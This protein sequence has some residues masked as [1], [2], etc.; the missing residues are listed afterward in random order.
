MGIVDRAEEV[1]RFADQPGDRRDRFGRGAADA[2]PDLDDR[3]VELAFGLRG[4]GVGAG[5]GRRLQ[6]VQRQPLAASQLVQGMMGLLC[7]LREQVG[8]GLHLGIDAGQQ[9]GQSPV[10][11]LQGHLAAVAKLLG[12]RRRQLLHRFE[13]IRF[14]AFDFASCPIGSTPRG[15]RLHPPTAGVRI[16]GRLGIALAPGFRRLFG[17]A[18]AGV[19]G[20]MLLETLGSG[21]IDGHGRFDPLSMPAQDLGDGGPRFATNGADLGQPGHQERIDLRMRGR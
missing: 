1:D 9:I 7:L 17:G 12:D 13:D 21:G 18:P 8:N 15:S 5:D 10:E 19:L 20:V 16:A 4:H 3:A 14:V 2:P 6:L 11:P